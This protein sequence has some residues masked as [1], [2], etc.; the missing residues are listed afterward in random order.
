MVK[1]LSLTKK[2]VALIL[3]LITVISLGL[4]L[5]TIDFSVS[6]VEDTYGYVLRALAHN[7][8]DFSEH[9]RKTLGWSIAISPF[10]NLFDSNSFL[11]YV[12]TARFL[13]IAISL[14]SI[15]AMYFLARKFFDQKY[16]LCAASFLAFEPHLNYNSG[17]GLSEPLYILIFIISFYFIINKN[18]NYSYLSF[19][20][21]A[22]LWWV[23]WS[24]VIML[25]VISIIFFWKHKKNRKYLAKYFACIGIFLLVSSPMLLQRND[26]FGDPLFFSQSTALFTGDYGAI[27]AEN[28]VNLDYGPFDYI[29]EHGITEFLYNF[30]LLGISNLITVIFKMSFPFLIVFLPFGILFSFRAFD[31]EKKSIRSIWILLLITLSSF[32]LY[33]AVVPEKRLIYHIFPFIIILCVIPLQRVVKYGL[34]TFWFSKKQKNYFLVGI[35]AVIIILSF[36]YTTRYDTVDPILDYERIEYGRYLNNNL[37]G[38]ILDAGY[39]LQGLKYV[40]LDDSSGAFKNYK[41]NMGVDSLTENKLHEVVIYGKSLDDFLNNAQEYDLKYLSINSKAVFETW[42]PYLED[43]YHNEDDYPFLTK[44]YDSKDMEYVEFHVKAFEI[45]YE[46]IP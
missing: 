6:P 28:T 38:K 46:K 21:V 36:T 2:N 39:T 43:V 14:I 3:I 40:K 45:E 13:S 19:F 15:T 4:K 30:F 44:I 41:T 26:D 32:I 12:N 20:S 7:T 42:Y 35:M 25:I 24:G 5:Y 17:H 34:T 23:R 22:L 33:F 37:D 8:G 16:S 31:Q 10:Y 18:S 27:L 1:K 9:P 29:E 11:D